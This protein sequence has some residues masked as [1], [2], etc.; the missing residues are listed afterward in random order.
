[1]HAGAGG[2]SVS[3]T[4]H[5]ALEELVAANPSDKNWKGIVI[6]I[7]V[8]SMVL[9]SVALSVFILTPM[10]DGPR[11]RGERFTINH[12]LDPSYMPRRFNASWVSDNEIVFLDS[13]GGLSILNVYTLNQ[14]QIV[15]NIVFVSI[16]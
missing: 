9:G 3:S 13:E 8:I 11:V 15:S 12:I 6:S 16:A 2:P 4:H 10:E 1:M 5:D 7:V 14:S